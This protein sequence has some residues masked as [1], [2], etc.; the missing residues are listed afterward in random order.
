MIYDATVS[1]RYQ[2]FLARWVMMKVP[3]EKMVAPQASYLH[4][5]HSQA[6]A[7]WFP[8]ILKVGSV[9]AAIFQRSKA[10]ALLR[11]GELPDALI[12]DIVLEPICFSDAP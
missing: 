9:G 6:T 2:H 10:I 1:E 12:S 11:S 3:A 7:D 5:C 4:A 8:Y